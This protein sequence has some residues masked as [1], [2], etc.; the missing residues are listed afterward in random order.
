M[1][2]P[3]APCPGCARHVR[4]SERRCPFC[5]AALPAGFGAHLAAADDREPDADALVWMPR[6]M[7]GHRE[8]L[9]R[10]IECALVSG[11]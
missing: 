2:R 1:Y 3:L 9:G 4:A 11:L 8:P 10:V 5:R 7:Q 6:G